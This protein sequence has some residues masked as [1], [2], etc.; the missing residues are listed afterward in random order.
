MRKFSLCIW[1]GILTF[2]LQIFPTFAETN[3]FVAREDVQAFIHTMVSKHH[4]KKTELQK[5]FSEVKIRPQIIASL[6]APLEKKPWHFYQR[7]FVSDWRVKNGLKFWKQHEAALTRAE[8]EYGVPAS[9]IVA[10]IGVETKYGQRIGDY[11]VIDSLSNIA[12][13]RSPRAKFFRSELTEFLL[14]AREQRLNPLKVM[15]SYAGAIGQPQFMPSSYRRYAVNFSKSGKTDLVGN[16]VD[17]IGSVANYYSKHGW[18]SHTPVAAKALM[19][20]HR[21]LY[22]VK[23]AEIPK[24]MRVGE[25]TRYGIVPENKMTSDEL[26]AK[27]IELQN[28][29]NKEYWLGFHNFEVIRRYNAS[30][31]YA[32]AVYQL[33]NFISDLRARDQNS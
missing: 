29:Y 25:L 11:R 6:N 14:L 12:F 28:Y 22:L 21:Y 4:F 2:C 19:I 17:V 16:Q 3:Q 10:T 31:L 1:L 13:S 24:Y 26:K 7:L 32:M 23:K 15:G 20:G 30:D 9:I 18:Q 8:K 5:L 27:V 33:S